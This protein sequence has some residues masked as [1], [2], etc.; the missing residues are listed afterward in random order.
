MAP[1]DVCVVGAGVAGIAALKECLRQG[2]KPVCYELDSDIG[3][4]WRKK[5]YTQ[6]HNTP[7][8]YNNLVMNTSK[9]NSSYS[10]F[11][12]L[13]QDTPYHSTEVRD[14]LHILKL[15]LAYV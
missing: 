9:F 2:F 11:P 14:T 6:P 13:L 7:A 4:I 5:D 12:P 1:K 15:V 10:D 8:A 3:G